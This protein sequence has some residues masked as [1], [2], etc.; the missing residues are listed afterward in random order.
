MQEIP[1]ED[2]Q[3]INSVN[4]RGL[5]SNRRSFPEILCGNRD[6]A[7]AHFKMGRLHKN[8]GIKYKVIGISHEGNRLQKMAAVGP[9][10]GVI[11]GQLLPQSN[12]LQRR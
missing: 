1:H 2:F 9:I 10:P 4:Q 8:L 5:E 11:L 6:F 7:N 12:I 3:G